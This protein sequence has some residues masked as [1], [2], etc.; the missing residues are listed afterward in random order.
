MCHRDHLGL[1]PLYILGMQCLE[2]LDILSRFLYVV[3]GTPPHHLTM[4]NI[5]ALTHVAKLHF[6]T[7]LVAVKSHMHQSMALRSA[8]GY[9]RREKTHE[10]LQRRLLLIQL[11]KIRLCSSSNAPFF[12]TPRIS[13]TS[14][15]Y[16]IHHTTSTRKAAMNSSICGR[17]L[18]AKGNTHNQHNWCPMLSPTFASDFMQGN[19]HNYWEGN[20]RSVTFSAGTQ[21]SAAEESQSKTTTTKEAILPILRGSSKFISS[22]V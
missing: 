2:I 12:G 20:K 9:A 19:A 3:A 22:R 11:Y 16:Y 10:A 4:K 17:R 6:F 14:F 5:S 7:E 13:I 15:T 1:W 8:C 21:N 18:E